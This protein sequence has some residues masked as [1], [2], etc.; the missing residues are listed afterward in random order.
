MGD[1]DVALAD[2]RTAVEAADR[3]VERDQEPGKS[4]RAELRN[5]IAA[6]DR[7]N[8]TR[9]ANLTVCEHFQPGFDRPLRE[10]SKL[11]DS[12]RPAP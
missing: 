1:A 3:S 10:R 11:L 4:L 5:N 7:K 8:P 6:L 2:L 12:M 9:V